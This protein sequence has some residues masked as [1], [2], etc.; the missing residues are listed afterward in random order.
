MISIV[1]PAFNA[2][3]YIKRAIQSVIS[4]TFEGWELIIVDD[5]STDSTAKIITEY[6]KK[7]NSIFYYRIDNTGSA[8]IPRD[9]AIY[10]AKNR[11]VLFLDSDDYLEQN[12]L[13]KVWKRHI[14][15]NADVVLGKMCVLD[16]KSMTI[17]NILPSSDYDCQNIYDGKDLVKDTLNTWKI[18]FNGALIDKAYLEY[19]LSYPKQKCDVWMN[20]D[21]VDSR[22]VLLQNPK[23]GFA[24]AIYYYWSNSQSITQAVSTKHF[25]YLCT[26]LELHSLIK[27]TFGEESRE[28]GL[29]TQQHEEKIKHV[30]KFMVLHSDI[31]TGKDKIWVQQKYDELFKATYEDKSLQKLKLQAYKSSLY[32]NLLLGKLG[33]RRCLNKV[34]SMFCNDE[35]KAFD[36]TRIKREQ[37][38][39][40]HLRPHYQ[41]ECDSE[42]EN[43][44]PYVISINNGFVEGGGLADRL[45]GIISTYMAAKELKRE[46]KLLFT[47]PFDLSLFL[48]PNEVNWRIDE[49][50]VIFSGTQSKVVVLDSVI[51]SKEH[52]RR[53]K[54]WLVNELNDSREY[55]THVYTNAL[56]SY[57]DNYSKYFN[58]L[59]KP[60]D[61]LQKAINKQLD[62]LG[63]D[64][65]S[66]SLRFLNLFNDFNETHGLSTERYTEE[67]RNQVRN[68]C[69][70]KIEALHHKYP[71][72][73][74]L[75]NSD[76]TSFLTSASGL[77]Y[78]YVIPGTITHID[79]EKD[80]TYETFEKTF[81]DFFMI[82]NASHIYL[83]QTPPM[84]QSGYPYAASF[85]YQRPFEII[86]F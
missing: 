51:G 9:C 81:L 56:F 46:F 86:K 53:Q 2:E 83:L 41:I 58:E 61:R 10:H 50:D 72:K 84:H 5:G 55:Q 43:I 24:D 45:R 70:E 63:K 6:S 47:C 32:I 29:L 73:K 65:I 42:T 14:E 49:S 18:G 1:M 78:V 3:K 35:D 27:K 59:F 25:H 40:L 74:I 21:E 12:Y 80:G 15:T 57:Y 20:S 28:M 22:Y 38:I 75:V 79:A 54:E 67:F 71:D 85:V 69:I 37:F 30:N 11:Y 48:I 76:S 31:L 36:V 16:S 19:R 26:E 4:Q 8:K 44:H 52:G 34:K 33:Y 17:A 7:Y 23:V 64:Y 82:A 13:Q 68:R 77:D 60:S 39:K 62:I 66:V